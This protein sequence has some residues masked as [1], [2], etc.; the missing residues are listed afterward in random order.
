MVVQAQQVLYKQDFDSIHEVYTKFDI[1]DRDYL[2]TII[3]NIDPDYI[4]N[5]I[6]LTDVDLCEKN[7]NLAYEVNV[8]GV[9]NIIS[10]CPNNC[11]LIH[12][13]TDYVFD[14]RKSIYGEKDSPNPICY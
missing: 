13:S 11:K 1:R 6:A 3:L 9:K 8:V 7:N 14:G 5:C 2:K 4:I 10:A 12:I